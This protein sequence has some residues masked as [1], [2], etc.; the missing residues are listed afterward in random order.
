LCWGHNFYGQCNVPPLPPGLSW[1]QIAAGA[2]HS[3]ARR[4]DGVIIAWGDNSEG[5]GTVP[6]LPAGLVWVEVA[7]GAN[8][9]HSIAR[10]SDGVAV[11]FGRNTDGQ[12][13]VPPLPQGLRCVEV[14]A[15]GLESLIRLG[16]PSTYTP[17]GA[18][19]AGTLP[20]ARLVPLD[21][22]R[23]G[24]LLELAIDNLP[25][26]V[27]LVFTGLS[28]TASRFGPLPL[29]LGPFGMPGCTA[30]T[31]DDAVALIV[32]AG[33]YGRYALPIP[34]AAFLVGLVFHQ[35]ALVLDPGVNALGIVI[36]DA[37]TAQ[38]GG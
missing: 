20:V 10:R 27:A 28:T 26:D 4:S 31:S 33:G 8:S 25:A 15:S 17:L 24:A 37:A 32:G 38:I 30:Y 34:S 2:R 1:V 3:L 5:Q 23:I 16:L 11:A 13:N 36:S 19:C 29:D 12:C 14:A 18:G 9:D 35:Q 6:P 21:T 22:P 7:A